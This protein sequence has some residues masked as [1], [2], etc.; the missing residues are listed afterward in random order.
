MA[1]FPTSCAL[2]FP[3]LSAHN[4]SPVWMNSSPCPSRLFTY[5]RTRSAAQFLEALSPSKLLP[6]PVLRQS[7]SSP[8]Y[9]QHCHTSIIVVLTLFRPLYL[10]P[11]STSPIGYPRPECKG[12]SLPL[13]SHQP[14]PFLVHVLVSD[15]LDSAFPSLLNW[16]SAFCC[17]ALC[18]PPSLKKQFLCLLCVVHI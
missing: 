16:H 7:S 9:V 10:A 18:K 13:T 11:H 1:L 2:F 14:S 4:L 6:S 15:L 5:F 17:W 8:C 3:E 12:S